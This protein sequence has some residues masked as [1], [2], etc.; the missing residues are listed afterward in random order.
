MLK[1][2][3]NN[4]FMLKFLIEYSKKF[5]FISFFVGFLSIYS[6]LVSIFLLRYIIDS[7]MSQKTEF[8]NICIVILVVC[9]F[10]V[11]IALI[12]S[13]YNN[14]FLPINTIRFR[15]FL[16]EKI[17]L[18]STEYSVSQFD[19]PAFYNDYSFV[20]GDAEKRVFSVYN[21]V[22]DFIV[23]I[24][25][26]F[27]VVT[28]VLVVFSEPLVLIF[29]FI[30][31]I[32]TTILFTRVYKHIFDRN[33][34]NL[35]YEREMG[36]IKRVFY[37]REYT[38]ELRLTNIKNVLLNN[39]KKASS[40]SAGLFLRYSK[41]IIPTN[42]VLTIIFE[43][44]NKFGLLVYLAW[45]AFAGAISIGDFSGLYSAAGSLLS[46]LQGATNIIKEFHKNN[47]YIE[48]FRV[49]YE[50]ADTVSEHP[51]EK[52][53]LDNAKDYEIRFKDVFFKYGPNDPYVLE[54]IN[55][56]V[57][58]GEK[59]AIVGHN[60]AGKTT[61]TNLLLKFYTVSK[62]SILFNDTNIENFE[63]S[64][65]QRMF[66]VVTQKFNIFAASIAENVKMDLVGSNETNHLYNCVA[67]VG[68]HDKVKGMKEQM[69]SMLTKEFN[70]AGVVL[71]GGEAQKIAL[72]RLFAKNCPIMILDEPS[73]ALDPISEH[74]IFNR[75]FDQYHDN[76]IFFVSHRLNTAA[77]ADKIIV[78]EKGKIVEMG[79]HDS[80]LNMQ[81]V[82]YKLYKATTDNY[83]I[84]K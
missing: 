31:L 27:F 50:T 81:G 4:F 73:S 9:T 51:G 28:T 63:S 56:S 37:L 15:S 66:N 43:L 80:L 13:W 19:N 24:V 18:K 75:I 57:K 7:V 1:T 60:G 39:F 41:K 74:E 69:N 11:L 23:N 48:K 83:K 52:L 8:L 47:P 20:I 49:F 61:L 40:E 33:Q 29:P 46:S 78:L 30:T 58:K 45:R 38:K 82:Y 26:F 76:T 44:F 59:I 2:I 71:S 68:L 64:S 21:S 10:S 55:F 14:K 53:V 67:A 84:T 65:Y 25:K 6:S 35:P 62:G 32:S 42:F 72:S 54:N 70:S 3:K 16:N 5:V 17:Y 36:Y 34:E 77:L 22:K 79:T 12:N